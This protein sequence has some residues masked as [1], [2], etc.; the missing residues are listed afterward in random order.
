[1]NKTAMISSIGIIRLYSRHKSLKNKT[2]IH[3]V[4]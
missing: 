4:K 3:I 1:M 2:N